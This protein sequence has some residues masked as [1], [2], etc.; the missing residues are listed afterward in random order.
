MVYC[1]LWMCY[2]LMVYCELRM[3]Y[4][5]MVYCIVNCGCT[6]DVLYTDGVL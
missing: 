1:E 6:V 5:L 3:C 2:I 4:I